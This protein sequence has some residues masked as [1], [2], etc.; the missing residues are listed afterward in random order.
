M[1]SGCRL[2]LLALLAVAS[3]SGCYYLRSADVPM[4]TRL[5]CRALDYQLTRADD[6]P[7][8]Q[9]AMIM[10][11]GIG[12]SVE[13]FAQEGLI[14][15][16]REANLPLDAIVADAHFGYYRDR[17]L[18]VRLQADVLEPA[19]RAGYHTLHFAG[20]SLG[21]FGSLLYWRDNASWRPASLTLLTPYLGE[22]EYYQYKLD[23]DVAPQQRQADK[24]L[25]PWL[26]AS[27]LTERRYWYVGLAR[28]GKFYQ[29][30]QAFAELLPE[31]NRVEVDG[32]HNWQ[33]WRRMWPPLLSVLQRDFYPLQPRSGGGI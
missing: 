5:Y 11:P 14:D 12:D 23:T 27:A 18:L 20:V 8:A 9:D 22:P 15:Q 33:A 29:P 19:K 7:R 31:A 28:S 13:R 1:V 26:D 4:Q 2:V 30:G 17:S 25:W 16:L 3:G 32:E 6:C 24:N 21:G 10:L